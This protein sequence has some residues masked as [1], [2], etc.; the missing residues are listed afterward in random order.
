MTDYIHRNI[1]LLRKTVSELSD[2]LEKE[3]AECEMEN[4]EIHVEIDKYDEIL[5]KLKERNYCQ[6]T[7]TIS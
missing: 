7:K 1:L 6:V 5:N 4:K 3:S 2:Y